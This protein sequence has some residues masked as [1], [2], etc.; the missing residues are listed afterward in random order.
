[1]KQLIINMLP[2]TYKNKKFRKN[3]I[4]NKNLKKNRMINYQINKNIELIF[5][6]KSLT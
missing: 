2:I 3:K 5:N 4:L 6:S 1:M